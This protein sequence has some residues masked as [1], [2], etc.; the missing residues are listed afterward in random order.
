MLLCDCLRQSVVVLG[1]R[2]D[3]V[4]SLQL[5]YHFGSG[6]DGPGGVGGLHGEEAFEVH[7][8]LEAQGNAPLGVE[9]EELEKM[10]L[11]LARLRIVGLSKLGKA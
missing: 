9:F 3:H 7:S 2:L 6:S 10:F 11:E 5:L 1:D 8:D 4:P